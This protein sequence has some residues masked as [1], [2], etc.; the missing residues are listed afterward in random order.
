MNLQNPMLSVYRIFAFIDLF[1]QAVWY[2][3]LRYIEY[4]PNSYRMQAVFEHILQKWAKW[5]Y[6]PCFGGNL[7]QIW[8]IE[9]E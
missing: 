8:G 5:V 1:T 4:T 3:N 7:G 2:H 9:W 6:K